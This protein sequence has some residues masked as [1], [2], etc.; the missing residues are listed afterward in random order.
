M[1]Y[2]W[3]EKDVRCGIFVCRKPN[4]GESFVPSDWNAKWMYK[5]GF[6]GGANKGSV[7]ISMSDGMVTKKQTP[8][9][10]AEYLTESN[11]MPMPH[12]WVIK[13]FEYMRDWYMKG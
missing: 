2:V 3:Q 13:M 7:L 10:M 1:I 12:K 8:K 11:M 5:I 4:Y 6:I 9:E